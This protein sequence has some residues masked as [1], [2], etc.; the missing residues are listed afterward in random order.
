MPKKAAYEANNGQL[1]YDPP[2]YLGLIAKAMW[3]KLVPVLSK[4]TN[5][6]SVDGSLVEQF[7]TQYEIYRNAYDHIKENGAVTPI[8]K[9]VQ[10]SAGEV[11]E[12]CFQGYKRN[13][14]SIIY[15]A[16]I[17]NLTK[18][19]S[20]LGLS[21]KSRAELMTIL[22]KKQDEKTAAEAMKE[23]LGDDTDED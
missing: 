20:D 10:N 11:L 8:Y 4:E 3:R 19:G 2:K 16:A 13:P 14:M 1:S 15:D 22:P 18:I 12:H 7:C 9:P 6:R 5:A 23:F 17:K 21:P